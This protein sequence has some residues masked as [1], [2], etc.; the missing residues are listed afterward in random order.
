MNILFIDGL[1]E[2]PYTSQ[3]LHECVPIGGTEIAILRVAELLSLEQDVIIA[4][5]ART[6]EACIDKIRYI[7]YDGA[8]HDKTLHPEIIIVIRPRRAT[9]QFAK[10]YPKARLFFWVHDIPGKYMRK[11]RYRFVK[12]HCAVIAISHFQK[13]KILANWQGNRLQRWLAKLF[14]KTQPAITVIYNPIA[15]AHIENNGAFHNNKLLFTSAPERGLAEVVALFKQVIITIPDLK[16]YVA[17]P[18]YTSLAPFQKIV[19]HPNIVILGNLP[20]RQ[21]QRHIA[22]SLCVFYPQT[23]YPESFGYVFAEANALGTPVLAHDFGAAKEVLSHPNQLVNGKDASAVINKLMQ[24]QQGERP[25]VTSVPHI[26]K[27]AVLSQ[28]QALVNP[29]HDAE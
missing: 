6:E 21:L 3:S 17:C 13:E 15:P 29:T 4:Q 11:Y 27:D 9:V 5:T 7:S 16:L 28:W 20:H 18:G 19:T 8:K 23:Q 14:Q 25:V 22:E 12:H 1:T 26:K 10:R 2:Y 24:W